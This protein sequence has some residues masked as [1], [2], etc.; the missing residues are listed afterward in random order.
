MVVKTV[1][2]KT[3]GNISCKYQYYDGNVREIYLFGIIICT[4]NTAAGV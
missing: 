4:D 1:A 2:L 3:K